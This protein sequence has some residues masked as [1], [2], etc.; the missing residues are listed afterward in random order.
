MDIIKKE[1]SSLFFDEFHFYLFLYIYVHAGSTELKDNS[2]KNDL[3]LTSIRLSI[4]ENTSS[5]FPTT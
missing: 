1:L 3:K 5:N 2:R 4:R